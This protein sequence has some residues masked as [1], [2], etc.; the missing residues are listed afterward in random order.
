ML[1]ARGLPISAMSKNNVIHSVSRR[2]ILGVG[3]GLLAG[4][5]T[6]AAVRAQPGQGF[7]AAWT[8]A[9]LRPS[10]EGEV[11]ASRGGVIDQSQAFAE[12]LSSAADAGRPLLLGPGQY[13]LSN[14]NLP[15]GSDIRGVPGQTKIIYA[16]D[17]YLFAA[18]NVQHI[19]L[20]NLSFD[21]ENRPFAERNGALFR[22]RKVARL[23][24]EGNR[25]SGS[26]GNAILLEKCGGSITGN[27]ISG[28]RLAG[29]H[30]FNGDQLMIAGNEIADSGNIGIGVW[31]WSAGNDGS[32]I[33][34]NTIRATA[35]L[36]GGTGQNGNGISIFQANNVQIAHNMIADSAFSAIRNNGGSNVQ[37]LGNQ[38]L[39]SA[40]VAI[41]IEFAFEGSQ[42]QNNLIDDAGDGISISN[43]DRGGRLALIQGNL[44]RNITRDF[45]APGWKGK[46][47]VGIHAE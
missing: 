20:A 41:F 23:H 44:I 11:F 6:A 26:A 40:E 18:Q 13:R 9:Q 36:D 34:N 21:G 10:I 27:F 30:S 31:R 28:S 43:F 8:T 12:A 5:G 17:G 25:F 39:R 1:V 19:R 4:A 7:D 22:G 35:A 15:E 37:V 45:S 46:T 47:G 33:L 32:Q 2:N 29:I 38:C 14:I 24:I 42:V 3:A 16:G